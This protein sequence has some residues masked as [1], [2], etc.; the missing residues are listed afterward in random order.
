MIVYG[1]EYSY[2]YDGIVESEQL[3]CHDVHK[4]RELVMLGPTPLRKA[5]V[6]LMV[7]RLADHWVADE[8][9]MLRRNCCDFAVA[10]VSEL[11]CPRHVPSHLLTL[12]KRAVAVGDTAHG[13]AAWLTRWVSAI[14]AGSTGGPDRL[15]RSQPIVFRPVGLP[16]AGPGPCARGR[17]RAL[18]GKWGPRAAPSRPPRAATDRPDPSKVPRAASFPAVAA[19][20][21]G[22]FRPL[23]RA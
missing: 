12:A 15:D 22:R 10:L 2:G 9:D 16:E 7:D 5:K 11:A 19:N 3:C 8:Y 1:R 14:F 6:A 21:Q 4:F 18:E 20:F 13:A 23:Q 17:P